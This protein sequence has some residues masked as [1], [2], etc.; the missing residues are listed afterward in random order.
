MNSRHS[1]ASVLDYLGRL[2]RPAQSQWQE[3][4][5]RL[6]LDLNRK[7]CE[8]S[9]GNKQKL[10]LVQAFAHQPELLILDEPTSGL[11]PIVQQ[12]FAGLVKAARANGQTV[13][14]SSH[15]LSEIE[16]L[17]ERVTVLR[18]GEVAMTATVSQLRA[19]LGLTMRIG[20]ATAPTRAILNQFAQLP[21]VRTARSEGHQIVIELDGSPDAVIKQ[22]AKHVVTDLT[23]ERPDLEAAVLG[24]YEEQK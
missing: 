8:L 1:V 5:E 21:Q 6:Q 16:H 2:A 22:A 15:V 7:V 19:A 10:G 13:F 20:L 4:A 9:R 18:K 12:E 14:L 23:A 3:I 24:L 17:A 11:D